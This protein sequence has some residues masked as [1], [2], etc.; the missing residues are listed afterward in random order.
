MATA[1]VYIEQLYPCGHGWPLWT[2]E[3]TEVYIGD[4]GFFESGTG[5]FCRLFN[6]LVDQDDPINRG[7]RGTPEGFEPLQINE[8]ADWISA[9][10]YFSPCTEVMAKTVTSTGLNL[11]ATA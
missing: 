7:Y 3:C 1:K 6:V 9:P 2:P 8:R 10:D 4:V 5:D 11:N